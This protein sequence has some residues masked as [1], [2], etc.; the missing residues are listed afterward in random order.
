[1]LYKPVATQSVRVILAALTTDFIVRNETD[2]VRSN[3]H[4]H[5]GAVKGRGRTEKSDGRPFTPPQ[6]D[7]GRGDKEDLESSLVSCALTL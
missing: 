3:M 4:A 1:M 7:R 2:N 5:T 6:R